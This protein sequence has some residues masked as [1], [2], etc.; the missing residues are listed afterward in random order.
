[1]FGNYGDILFFRLATFVNFAVLLKSGTVFGGWGP[2]IV[3]AFV[4]CNRW[5]NHMSADRLRYQKF[6]LSPLFRYFL[7]LFL[8]I[9]LH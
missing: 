3:N 2:A 8:F 7:I 4:S 5:T 1:M 6:D 9:F